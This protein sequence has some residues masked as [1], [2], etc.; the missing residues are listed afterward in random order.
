MT[1]MTGL[2]LGVEIG[3]KKITIALYESGVPRVLFS[4]PSI[5][6]CSVDRTEWHFGVDARNYKADNRYRN[7][8]SVKGTLLAYGYGEQNPFVPLL[9]EKLFAFIKMIGQTERKQ[10]LQGVVVVLSH[11]LHACQN[12][13]QAVTEA[14]QK[15]D[16]TDV[17]C[18]SD[19]SAIVLAYTVQTLDRQSIKKSGIEPVN[20][21]VCNADAEHFRMGVFEVINNNLVVKYKSNQYVVW[22]CFTELRW[23]V[24]DDIHQRLESVG[25]PALDL[26]LRTQLGEECG[27][28]MALFNDSRT[29]RVI[30]RAP[31]PNCIVTYTREDYQA[32]V[33]PIIE[34][35]RKHVAAELVNFGI[36]DGSSGNVGGKVELLVVG[37]NSR[38]G[39][40][41]TALEGVTKSQVIAG[42]ASYVDDAEAFGAA[43]ASSLAGN[44]GNLYGQHQ[45]FRLQEGL[46]FDVGKIL[47][48]L[49]LLDDNIR[50]QPARD[51]LVNDHKNVALSGYLYMGNGKGPV[52]IPDFRLVLS[53]QK[54]RSC[55]AH[56]VHLETSV[57]GQT[58][59]YMRMLLGKDVRIQ[60][61]ELQR[62]EPDEMVVECLR[63]QVSFTYQDSAGRSSLWFF[64]DDASAYE[65]FMAEY[66]TRRREMLKA[67]P[68]GNNADE[69]LPKLAW[70]SSS[71]FVA[72]VSDQLPTAEFQEIN[73][74]QKRPSIVTVNQDSQHGLVVVV[75]QC[76]EVTKMQMRG[77]TFAIERP[78]KIRECSVEHDTVVIELTSHDCVRVNFPREA[79][80][81]DFLKKC[82]VFWPLGKP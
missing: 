10:C 17:L 51:I 73:K 20:V 70:S 5:A 18:I 49:P 60:C 72:L 52:I 24:F 9:L 81:R 64:A 30:I 31:V 29:V 50:V 78:N 48:A 33:K 7:F 8:P 36:M 53:T 16:L 40:L 32:V 12:I 22:D 13:Y 61:R 2:R 35:I 55:K 46:A 77:N 3:F 75:Q 74:I 62:E 39:L 67:F 15:N 14:W 76:Q 44:S 80:R 37:E 41:R 63:I 57:D 59:T 27:D 6:A 45:L 4:F 23:R 26:H 38:L 65:P 25:M 56:C 28:H 68:S 42:A 82:S 11:G 1:K 19:I 58:M 66:H 34:A 71:S 21:L 79:T 47:T 43:I 69:S 54:I